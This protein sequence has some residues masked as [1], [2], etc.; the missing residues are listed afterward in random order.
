[1]RCAKREPGRSWE[2][3][4]SELK[5]LGARGAVAPRSLPG[6]SL[7][8]RLSAV[9]GQT[10]ARPWSLGSNTRH[11]IS[12]SKHWETRT[13]PSPRL[14]GSWDTPD[15]SCTRRSALRCPA[16]AQARTRR[17]GRCRCRATA[18][19]RRRRSPCRSRCPPLPA[20]SAPPTIPRLAKC[21]L[22]PAL[23]LAQPSCC[24]SPLFGLQGMHAVAGATSGAGRLA[25]AGAGGAQRQRCR[26]GP[27]SPCVGSKG[28]AVS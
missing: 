6:K 28:F 5:K 16:I 10:D 22:A 19:P 15:V 26:T 25:T 9:C 4:D 21:A 27:S 1:M 23:T 24:G 13:S 3:I 18:W 14:D 8:T 12:F 11:N 20:P 7:P 2:A 17:P